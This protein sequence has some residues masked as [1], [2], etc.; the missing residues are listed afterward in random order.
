MDLPLSNEITKKD[1]QV[2]FHRLI[3]TTEFEMTEYSSDDMRGILLPINNI[4]VTVKMSCFDNFEI[5]LFINIF[6]AVQAAIADRVPI[7]KIYNIG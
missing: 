6:P 7:Y 1:H 2:D 4:T 5:V 3:Q